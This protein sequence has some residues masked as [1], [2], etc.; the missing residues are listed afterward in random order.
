MNAISASIDTTYRESSI[1]R[2]FKEFIKDT[3]FIVDKYKDWHETVYTLIFNASTRT[4]SMWNMPLVKPLMITPPIVYEIRRERI[5]E[6]N[7]YIDEI[8]I[9]TGMKNEHEKL[10]DEYGSVSGLW[11]GLAVL[12][13]STI[14]GIVVPT[15]LL[16][17]PLGKYDDVATRELLI[18]LF[19]TGLASLFIYLGISMYK[20]TRDE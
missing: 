11:S 18:V 1:P 9:L 20:L 4:N 14:V 2:D 17:Y 6:R 10:L 13:Y 5:K 7:N 16:P 15:L 19:F 12:A 3:D 8:K